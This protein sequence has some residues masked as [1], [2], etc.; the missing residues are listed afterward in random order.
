MKKRSI[1]RMCASKKR[2]KSIDQVKRSRSNIRKNSGTNL[3]YY[4]CKWC[5][6]WHLTNDNKEDKDERKRRRN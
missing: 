4:K 1:T 5:Q 2:F 3:R 6:G